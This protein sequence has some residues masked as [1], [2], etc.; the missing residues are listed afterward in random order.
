MYSRRL[1]PIRFEDDIT[2]TRNRFPFIFFF[3]LSK[4]APEVVLLVGAPQIPSLPV[5]FSCS[6]IDVFHLFYFRYK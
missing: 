4:L 6:K 1:V 5:L 3:L 2:S